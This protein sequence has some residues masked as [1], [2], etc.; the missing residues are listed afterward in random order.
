MKWNK[1]ENILVIGYY[2]M[3]GNVTSLKNSEYTKHLKIFSNI[4]NRGFEESKST[5]RL[6]VLNV[7]SFQNGNWK[8][9]GGLEKNLD[10]I[11]LWNSDKTLIRYKEM[12]GIGKDSL[13][14]KTIDIIVKSKEHNKI[15]ENKIDL[16]HFSYKQEAQVE[17]LSET[18]SKYLDRIKDGDF[19]IPVFQ[20]KFVWPTQDIIDFLNSLLR[21]FPFGNITV[22]TSER[23]ALQERNNIIREFRKGR[24]NK[25]FDTTMWVIDGQQRTTS[26]VAVLSLDPI[27]KE[28][29]KIIYSLDK[30]EFKKWDK[31]DTNFIYARHFLNNDFK[32]EDFNEH[33]EKNN[34]FIKIMSA[35]KN[36]M[37]RE[38]GITK[39][40]DADLNVAIDIFT[41]MNLK[42]KKL[43]LFQI[44]HAKFLNNKINFDLESLYLEW[45]KKH[46][47]TEKIIDSVTFIKTLYL[48]FNEN[49]T[50]TKMILNYEITKEH[51]D[52]NNVVSYINALDRAW[53]FLTIQM[54][55]HP[56][57]LPSSNIIR[58][59]AL[60]YYKNNTKE[61]D[62]RITKE[63][64]SYIRLV[65]INDYY[66]SS[67]DSKISK[68]IDHITKILKNE[69]ALS[70]KEI[71]K[72]FNE[73]I[74]EE[75]L[76]DIKYN[77]NSSKY[78]YILNLL[79]A[80]AKSLES[81]QR[82]TPYSVFEDKETLNIHH[83]IPKSL[84]FSGDK[85]YKTDYGNSIVN[86]APILATENKFISD[87]YPGD[88]YMNFKSKNNEIDSTLNSLYINPSYIQ[89]ITKDVTMDE[90][91]VFWNERSKQ[92]IKLIN[93]EN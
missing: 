35:R 46:N 41:Q 88:Y 10:F 86:L 51:V 25:L 39:I 89:G 2:K 48:F 15:S 58:F 5:F 26:I 14:D 70:S 67:T 1:D 8:N 66:S 83:I 76:I 23:D 78:L 62:A 75:K 34:S 84:S 29:E 74:T 38:I 3:H 68:N 6:K 44:I 49:N 11:E 65:C 92:L 28:T 61:F 36:F 40:N 57:L 73:T 64:K 4:Q 22:W 59:L 37:D 33:Y 30:N 7:D 52:E 54:K 56:R 63:M 13:Q 77:A 91:I 50:T 90:C 12:I 47:I 43:T 31:E 81:N 53:E 82:L 24:D 71:N 93:E 85:V 32:I 16:S 27:H 19:K 72:E 55:F 45:I 80:N 60:A 87:S 17:Y 20:R 42:G 9:A 69:N 79:F 21:G 18:L